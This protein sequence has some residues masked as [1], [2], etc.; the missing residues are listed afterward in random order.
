MR[1]PKEFE[2]D[3]REVRSGMKF[4]AA[5]FCGAVVVTVAVVGALVFWVLS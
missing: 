5:V 4:V 3:D 2:E 1:E